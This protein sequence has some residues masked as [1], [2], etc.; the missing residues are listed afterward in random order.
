L[1]G[2]TTILTLAAGSAIAAD[3]RVKA[4]VIPAVIYDWTGPFLGGGVSY[5]WGR[6]RDNGTYLPSFYDSSVATGTAPGAVTTTRPINHTIRGWDAEIQG[7]YRRQFGTFVAGLEGIARW[8]NERGSGSCFESYP[9]GYP[10]T[11][12]VHLTGNN[13][14]NFSCYKSTK[15]RSTEA[16]V[17]QAG[18]LASPSLLL[19]L[20]GGPALAQIRTNDAFVWAYTTSGTVPVG[21]SS[22][23]TKNKGGYWVGASA[24]YALPRSPW[25]IK[26]EYAYMSFGNVTT[27]TTWLDTNSV[28]IPTRSPTGCVNTF[29]NGRRVNDNAV[30]LGLNYAFGTS[31]APISTRY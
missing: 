13:P 1:L 26:L 5:S 20:T 29:T 11:S 14:G 24:E 9:T 3:M 30:L 2:T 10:V 17:V 22:S 19:S 4:P 23:A 18:V 12:G 7:G 28:C 16:L 31:A 25:H 8:T 27:T 21:G 6:V 15:L